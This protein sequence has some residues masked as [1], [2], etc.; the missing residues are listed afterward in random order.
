MLGDYERKLPGSPPARWDAA[1]D[2][3]HARG[4][5]AGR[6]GRGL[7]PAAAHLRQPFRRQ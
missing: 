6:S 1:A 4:Q 7:R 2:P 3:A 5:A